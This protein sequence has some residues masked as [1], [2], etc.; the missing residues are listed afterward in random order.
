MA[1]HIRIP[2]GICCFACIFF[3]FSIAILYMAYKVID[4]MVSSFLSA[5][6]HIEIDWNQKMRI[7]N[8]WTP[9]IIIVIEHKK[10]LEKKISNTNT[11][12]KPIEKELIS[13]IKLNY[14]TKLSMLNDVKAR[15]FYL[16]R[17]LHSVY[18]A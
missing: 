15:A 11:P 17:L 12:N 3:F 18:Q 4:W 8:Q 9:R 14:V 13:V 16:L 7:Q 5:T 10:N 1:A 2:I 6:A